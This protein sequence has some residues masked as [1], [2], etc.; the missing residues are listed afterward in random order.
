MLWASDQSMWE[1]VTIQLAVIKNFI[2]N[3]QKYFSRYH[4]W[5]LFCI[6]S[7]FYPSWMFLKLIYK[8]FLLPTL[9]GQFAGPCLSHQ[10]LR[11]KTT[12]DWWCNEIYFQRDFCLRL[13]SCKIEN[14]GDFKPLQFQLFPYMGHDD[15]Y[16]LWIMTKQPNGSRRIIYKDGPVEYL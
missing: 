2:T 8:G 10:K 14:F 12:I 9:R 11:V 15:L 7:H 5:L 3:T 16:S 13:I 4:Y 1:H 6:I